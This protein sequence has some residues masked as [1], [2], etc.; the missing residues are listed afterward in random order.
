M[1]TNEKEQKYHPIHD[2]GTA[3]P[4][5]MGEVV[6]FGAI[7][8]TFYSIAVYG[9]L[10]TILSGALYLTGEVIKKA[11]ESAR[12]TRRFNKLEEVLRNPK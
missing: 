1:E 12:D 10:A 5:M 2:K 11:G 4:I 3:I 8:C 6:K 9:K 7:I